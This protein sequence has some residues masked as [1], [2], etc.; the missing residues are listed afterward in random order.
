MPLVLRHIPSH[1]SGTIHQLFADYISGFCTGLKKLSRGSACRVFYYIPQSPGNTVEWMTGHS[2]TLKSQKDQNSFNLTKATYLQTHQRQKYLI[3]YL[4]KWPCRID[5][6]YKNFRSISLK[7][8]F[9]SWEKGLCEYWALLLQY[10]F[11]LLF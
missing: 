1:K 2:F 5:D 4:T 11:H 9:N 7:S 6:N 10:V 3:T 8:I